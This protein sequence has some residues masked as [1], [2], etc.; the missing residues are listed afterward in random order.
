MK[1]ISFLLV[2]ILAMMACNQQA[3]KTTVD[4][5]TTVVIDTVVT[6]LQV[7]G[8]SCDGCE[9]TIEKSVSKL[10]GIFEV[11]A[12]HEDSTTL[13]KFDGNQT[14][15]EKIGEAIASKGYTMVGEKAK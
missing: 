5:K 10:P 12:D 2:I 15:L 7:N 8:M 9:A 3:K 1:K 11:K 6:L 4:Q 13:V 14:N